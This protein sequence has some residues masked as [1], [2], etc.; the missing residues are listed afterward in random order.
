MAGFLFYGTVYRES[1]EGFA[2]SWL[3]GIFGSAALLFIVVAVLTATHQFGIGAYIVAGMLSAIV[4]FEAEKLAFH[5]YRRMLASPMLLA[6]GAFLLPI[7]VFPIFLHQVWQIINGTAQLKD[8]ETPTA[9]KNP[10]ELRN[11][12]IAIGISI[13]GIAGSVL[14]LM[15]FPER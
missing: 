6:I 2:M 4:G 10:R 14:F 12:L 11:G 7:V 8:S 9:E 13:V 5:K 15:N 3:V 1:T